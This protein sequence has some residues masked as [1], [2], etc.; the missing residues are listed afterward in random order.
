MCLEAA[1]AGVMRKPGAE[2]VTVA[3]FASQAV[4]LREITAEFPEDRIVA[5]ESGGQLE[6]LGGVDGLAA[7]ALLA[8]ASGV[9]QL[10]GWLDYSGDSV[11][12]SY[13]AIDPID[14]T[15][16]FVRGDQFAVAVGLVTGD[17]PVAGVLGCPRLAHE[18]DE[19]V[20][21]WGGPAIGAF[22][23]PLD[24]SDEMPVAV[25]TIVEPGEARVLGSF[26]PAHGDPRLLR[27]VIDALGLGGGWVRMD[28]QAKYAAVALGAAEIYLRPRHRP[29]Y[30]ERVWDHAAGAA[31]VRGAGGTVTDVDGAPLDFAAGSRL[32]NNRGVLATNGLVHDEVLETI[33]SLERG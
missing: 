4:L 28:S 29:Q 8:G 20:L 18:G 33:V 5:E 3:D 12:D 15:N 31:I 30:R 23:E 21:V 9:Q 7:V 22:V 11:S 16:G 1:D 24:G 27:A 25:S 26:E 13:W 14:G 10:M 6:S 19:G 32:E 2:P 17:E